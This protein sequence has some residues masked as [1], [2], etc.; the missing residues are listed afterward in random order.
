MIRF[1]SIFLA[2]SFLVTLI[3]FSTPAHAQSRLQ[4]ISKGASGQKE[5][6]E[7]EDYVDGQ[8]G[9]AKKGIDTRYS[10]SDGTR[11]ANV[12]SLRNPIFLGVFE[13]YL[14]K[15]RYNARITVIGEARKFAL[16][17]RAC[18]KIRK[19]RDRI[20]AYLFDN[21]P[22]TDKRGRVDPTGMDKGIRKAIKEALKTKLEYFTTIH[23]VNGRYG[24]H[25]IP[26]EM[27][28]AKIEDCAGVFNKKKE[29]DK[30]AKK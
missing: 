22:T 3:D 30:A 4:T 26:K 1:F 17:H 11:R 16:G 28:G 25:K 24:P 20:N 12:A 19:I 29:M 5:E 15:K 21:P 14:V 13:T 23:V 10:G 2:L 8:K 7:E 27:E 6:K 18:T 9:K